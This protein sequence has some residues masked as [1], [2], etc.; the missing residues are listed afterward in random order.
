[1]QEAAARAENGTRQDLP[2]L[3]LFPD[4]ALI[5]RG[6][7][8]LGGS[9]ASQLAEDFGTPLVVYCE[10]TVRRRARTFRDAVGEG[11][12]VFYGTKAF[13]NVALLRLFREEGIGADVAALGELAFARAAGLSG[14]E[15]VVHGNNKDDALLRD[16]AREA[17]PVV[18]DGS[19]E[20]ELAAE[21]GVRRV[22]VRVTVGVDADTH[23]AIVTG[24]HGSKFGL[25]P[26][27]AQE[28][29]ADALARGLEVLGLHV[30]VGSQ[31]PDF[32]AQAATIAR[33]A[34]FAATCR[35][36]L[37]WTAGVADP[38]GGVG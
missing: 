22:L 6:E 37:G 2:M 27:H 12:R 4:S 33:L 13:P 19:D 18:I 30:H 23:E 5:E 36:V 29:V 15:L 26:D 34:D 7:L 20:V 24:H 3:D 21:A 35:D 32:T 11:G 38:G 14:A 1:M 8:Q 17:A 31:L 10:D 28:A 25:P 9:S 16:A